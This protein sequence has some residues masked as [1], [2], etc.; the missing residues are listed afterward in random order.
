MICRNAGFGRFHGYIY[1]NARGVRDAGARA[2]GRAYTA[3]AGI[4]GD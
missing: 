1:S 4:D 2:R 3:G